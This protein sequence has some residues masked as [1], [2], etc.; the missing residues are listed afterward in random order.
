MIAPATAMDKTKTV[1][2]DI[3]PEKLVPWSGSHT[4]DKFDPTL[5]ELKRISIKNDV[6][7]RQHMAVTAYW[8]NTEPITVT[9]YSDVGITV[10]LPDAS[11]FVN[12]ATMTKAKVLAPNEPWVEDIPDSGTATRDYANLA[13]FIAT[14]PGEK[15][16]LPARALTNSRIETTGAY[17]G[18]ARAYATGHLEVTY[19][20]DSSPVVEIKKFTNG[21][22][23]PNAPGPYINVGDPVTWTY[24]VKN[25][26][27]V[28]LHNIEV[29]DNRLTPSLVGTIPTLAHGATAPIITAPVGIATIGQYDNTGTVT[30]LSPDNDQVTNSYDS[31]YFGQTPSIAIKKYTNGYDAPS[32]PGPYINVGD[33]VTWTYEVTNTGNVELHDI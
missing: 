7:V 32:V 27:N 2:S 25:T 14:T 31:H 3:S 22:D 19:T 6:G 21:Y 10:T 5:G 11:T 17:D 33:P 28:D 12:T 16:T 29:T 23:A 30:A 9:L 1:V 15:I 26:G 13:D 8:E 24:E 18:T 20:Y 4:V